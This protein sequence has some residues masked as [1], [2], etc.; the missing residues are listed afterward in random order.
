MTTD[1]PT[2]TAKRITHAQAKSEFDKLIGESWY[3]ALA[4]VK[5]QIAWLE[6]VPENEIS[7]GESERIRY[8]SEKLFVTLRVLNSKY[9]D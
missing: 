4:Q 5:N 7:D 6:Y 3:E 2:T 9:N 8:A 1:K